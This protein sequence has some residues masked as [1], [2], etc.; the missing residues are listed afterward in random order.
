MDRMNIFLYFE[1]KSIF[2][3]ECIN[4]YRYIFMY[5]SYCHIHELLVLVFFFDMDVFIEDHHYVLWC[6]FL[7]FCV[8]TLQV[9]CFSICKLPN[10][11]LFGMQ[12][13]QFIIWIN[14]HLV[15][16]LNTFGDIFFSYILLITI[17]I[18]TYL[19]S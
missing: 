6:D 11:D 10:F 17:I 5:F 1:N 13:T 7:L 16:W 4:F 9:I 3:W 18:S 14:N 15:W 19:C 8:M 12:C 2:I